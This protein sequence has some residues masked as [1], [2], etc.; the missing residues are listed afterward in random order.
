MNPYTGILDQPFYDQLDLFEAVLQDGKRDDMRHLAEASLFFMLVGVLGRVDAM[1]PWLA[2]RC[3]EVQTDPDGRLDL[4]ARFH[5]KSTIITFAQTLWDIAKDPEQTFGIFSHT[6][7]IAGAFLKQL[8][9]EMERNRALHHL[10]PDIFWREPRKESPQWAQNTGLVVRRKSNPKEAT[11]EAWGL[12]DGQPTSRHYRTQVYDDVV[13]LESVGTPDQ[14]AKT[15]VAWEISLALGSEDTRIRY[16]GTRYHPSD[17]YSEIIKRGSAKP[18]VNAATADGTPSGEPVLL[19]RQRLETL[20]R[21]MG[22]RAFSAQMLLRPVSADTATFREEWLCYYQEPPP[23]A[24]M[25]IWI[26]VDPAGGKDKRGRKDSQADYS[27]FG[28]IGLAQDQNYYLLPGT[29][30]DRLNLVQ[31]ADTLFRLKRQY[32]TAQVGYEEY[33]IQADIEHI[34]DR[35]TRENYRFRIIPVG[36]QMHKMQRIE[37]L[38]PIFS[39]GRFWIP[40]RLPYTAQD[41]TIR[42]FTH[43]FT[44]DEY[45]PCPVLPHDD[46][47]DAIARI[48]DLPAVFPSRPPTEQPARSTPSRPPA[49]AKRRYDPLAR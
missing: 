12:V 23:A 7:G 20:Q 26:L 18:R 9:Q 25:N 44:Q 1:R 11:I 33:G 8:Q 36:G 24:S 21:D 16:A 14:I 22:P 3:R 38:V 2:D 46:M 27:V 40:Y 13:T 6:G 31:R 37:R 47:L 17:T 43:E 35:M 49:A 29:L 4:W 28:V 10:W 19:T 32:P 45:L 42:D 34:R 5:Y 15:T 48:F 39:A 30:R 41:G